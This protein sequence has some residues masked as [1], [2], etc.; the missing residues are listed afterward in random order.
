MN[1][2]FWKGWCLE[3][4]CRRLHLAVFCPFFWCG[5][6]QIGVVWFQI[7]VV[8]HEGSAVLGF[9]GLQFQRTQGVLWGALKARYL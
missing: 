5:L 1:I 6:K 3:N 9:A 8:A 4:T 2:P 7:A